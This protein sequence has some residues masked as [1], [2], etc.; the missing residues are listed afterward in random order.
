TAAPLG[1]G[2]GDAGQGEGRNL[3]TDLDIAQDELCAPGQ[4]VPVVPSGA[5]LREHRVIGG[6]RAVTGSATTGPP[7]QSYTEIGFNPA[8]ITESDRVAVPIQFLFPCRKQRG[9]AGIDLAED[10]GQVVVL[11]L[12][13]G[14]VLYAHA[15]FSV[16]LF[17]FLG[18]LEHRRDGR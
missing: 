1:S 4:D 10:V 2:E 16:A 18:L 6:R 3:R 9:K 11:A 17:Q 13:R 12:G 14:P 15:T 8:L 7:L 5:G